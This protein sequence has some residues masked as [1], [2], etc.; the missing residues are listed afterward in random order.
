MLPF[1][2]NNTNYRDVGF[3]IFPYCGRSSLKRLL[4]AKTDTQPAAETCP[5][6]VLQ[7]LAAKDV[8]EAL[9]SSLEVIIFPKLLLVVMVCVR[10]NSEV[11]MQG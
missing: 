4:Q 7:Q 6:R 8:T 5:L 1:A 2:T 3:A 10:I 9:R 11:S